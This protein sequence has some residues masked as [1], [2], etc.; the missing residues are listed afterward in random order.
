MAFTLGA[1]KGA[2]VALTY[3]I[4]LQVENRIIQPVIVSKAVDI[5]PFVAMVAVL[6]GGAVAGVVGALL[7][8]PFIAVA[9]SLHTEFRGPRTRHDA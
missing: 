6:I 3:L 2:I 8:T 5:P 7:V 4:Y 1:T 9:T